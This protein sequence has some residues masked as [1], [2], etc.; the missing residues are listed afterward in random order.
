MNPFIST[1]LCEIFLI[2]PISTC[3][4]QIWEYEIKVINMHVKDESMKSALHTYYLP[5][6][7]FVGMVF[8]IM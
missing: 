2:H 4:N 5:T 7:V 6:K 1:P 3:T 8:L